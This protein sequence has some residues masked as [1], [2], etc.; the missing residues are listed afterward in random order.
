L[1]NLLIV[2]VAFIW[3]ESKGRPLA[4]KEKISLFFEPE[5][6]GLFCGVL[7]VGECFFDACDVAFSYQNTNRT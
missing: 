2:F 3:C 7:E 1:L 4:C 5:K 6:T